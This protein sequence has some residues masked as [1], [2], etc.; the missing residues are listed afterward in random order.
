[1]EDAKASGYTYQVRDHRSLGISCGKLFRRISL[2]LIVMF[3]FISSFC[4]CLILLR[5]AVADRQT[6]VLQK[7]FHP[8]DK[9][10]QL[11]VINPHNVIVL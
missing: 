8:I 3:N 5:I 7:K 6:P 9:K 1:M 2:V 10:C 11:S 4:R